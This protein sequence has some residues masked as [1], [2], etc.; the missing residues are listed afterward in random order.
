MPSS[1]RT[2]HRRGVVGLSSTIRLQRT[3]RDLGVE[4]YN[5]L[6]MAAQVA[7]DVF[8]SYQFRQLR[9]ILQNISLDVIK[10]LIHAFISC[11]FDYCNSLYFGI[12]DEL[13]KR[14]QAA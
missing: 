14:Q 4:I 13:M 2:Q 8:R 5:H 10:A 12:S 3:A 11:H 9:T 6:T 7:T 1:G